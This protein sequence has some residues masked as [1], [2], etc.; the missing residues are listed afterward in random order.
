MDPYLGYEIAL[1][2]VAVYG[3]TVYA[4]YRRGLVGPDRALSLLGPALMIKT[5]RGR[6]A[7]ERWARFRRFWTAAAD[8]GI[9]LAA[10]AMAGITILLVIDAIVALRIPASAAPPVT[11][12]LGLPGINPVIPIGYGIVALV[13]GIVLHE[14]AHGVVARS[15]GIGVKTIGVLWCVVPVGAFVE[16]DDAD[17]QAATRRR[18]DRVAAAGVLA[19]FGLALLFFVALSLLVASSVAPNAN[20]VGV[21]LVEPNTP[22]ANATIAPGDIITSI[23][24][25]STTTNTLFEASLADTHPGEVVPVVFFSAALGRP[26]S[27]NV[28]LAPSPTIAGRGFL[29]VAVTFLT[30]P[31]L[32]STLVWPLGSSSGPLTGGIDW[33]VLPLATIEPIGG[34]TAQFFHLTG[35]LAGT[36]PGSFWIG[37]NVLYWLAWMNLLLGL[38][39]ALPLVPLDG[40]LLFRDF[41]SSIAARLRAGW[42]AARLEEFGSRAVAASSV[43]VLVLLLW[44]FIVPRLL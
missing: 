31:Q 33:L 15:Q 5:R 14:L 41:A 22:A 17:M 10:I 43:I 4:L 16:Q 8:L 34:S 42:S 20:G 18:R 12:A 30:P 7:L 37:A 1:L 32:Q 9:A 19:N 26:V 23:N 27:V 38:S 36:D 40:G 2:V 6:S 39:N 29:G 11:E 44:Q 3:G 28:T 13:V 25:T 21:A 24:G 35:P